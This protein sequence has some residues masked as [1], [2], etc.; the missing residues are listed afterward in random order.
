MPLSAPWSK[1]TECKA[2]SLWPISVHGTNMVAV[3]ALL[4]GTCL[5]GFI[6]GF[7]T[8][9][10]WYGYIEDCLFASPELIGMVAEE[11]S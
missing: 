8:N 4:C 7:K 1:F 9:T 2:T 6:A 3:M 10:T 11:Q 5:D